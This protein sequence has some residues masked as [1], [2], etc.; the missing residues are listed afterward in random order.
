VEQFEKA[1]ADYCGSRFA[2]AVNSGTS[3][4]HIAC[5]AADLGP[6]DILWTSP[7]TFVASANCALYCGA[8]VDFVDIDPRTCNMSVDC[9][10]EKLE[11]AER[12]GKLPKV[13]IPVHFAGQSC[14]MEAIQSLSQRYGFRIIED[15]SH[16]IGGRYKGNP[17]GNCR[18]SDMTIFSFHP[19]KI[20]TS[21]EGGMVLTNS[22]EFHRRLVRL[23]SHGITRDPELMAGESHGPWYYQ[24]IELG[25]NYR[26]TDIQAALGLSQTM[27]L[28]DFVIRRRRLAARYDS[29]LA[30]LPIRG[31]SLREECVCAYHLYVIILESH[32]R[33]AIFEAL[34]SAGIG[35]NV[36]YL[37]VHM[38]PYFARFGFTAGMFPRAEEYYRKALTLPLFTDMTDTQF[39][40]VVGTVRGLLT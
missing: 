30:G 33:A 37:P 10:R 18:Y 12:H 23:R 15:A 34:R 28:D 32:R 38:Q 31:I 29:A 26:M 36:H 8:G 14:E 6:G 3:A 5:L 11:Q 25:Y 17:V 1:V 35:V 9:L 4:L 27:R 16:A 22:S 20:I 2:V 24:Q 13:V 39:R 40:H 7:V 21:G 19:V